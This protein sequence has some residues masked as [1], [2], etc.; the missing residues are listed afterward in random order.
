MKWSQ[1]R[2]RC[3][4]CGK[5]VPFDTEQRF[6][7]YGSYGEVEPRE[8]EFICDKCAKELQDE[9]HSIED[10]PRYYYQLPMYVV[11]AAKKLG[12]E[13]D[14]GRRRWVKKDNYTVKSSSK[15]G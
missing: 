9:I 3:A 7:L 11:E 14:W 15:A 10:L 12:A 1:Y 13:Y 2:F 6:V 8:E 4:Y 5:F